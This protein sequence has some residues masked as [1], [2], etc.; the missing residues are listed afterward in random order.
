M[1]IKELILRMSVSSLCSVSL[2]LLGASLTVLHTVCTLFHWMRSSNNLIQIP[3]FMQT[4]KWV[5]PWTKLS[6]L[7]DK[8]TVSILHL[9][10]FGLW[11]HFKIIFVVF[12]DERIWKWEVNE[13]IIILVCVSEWFKNFFFEFQC[14]MVCNKEK[15]LVCRLKFGNFFLNHSTG[16]VFAIYIHAYT[17]TWKRE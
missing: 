10:L 8:E 14:L 3:S 15:W 9:S 4:M 16:Y 12:G 2:I 7:N 11:I 6:L 17:V 5:I 1:V 13:Y